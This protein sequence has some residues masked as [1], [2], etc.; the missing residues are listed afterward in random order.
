MNSSLVD[1]DL[2]G[3]K[4]EIDR[5][6]MV[7]MW[8]H[9]ATR[10]PNRNTRAAY[11]AALKGLVEFTARGGGS[12]RDLEPID[13][14]AWLQDQLDRHSIPTAK[15][16]LAGIRS[17]FDGLVEHGLLRS[18]PA[19]AVRAPRYSLRKGKTPVLSPSEARQILSAIGTSSVVGLRDRAIIATML[20]SFARIGAVLRLN[21]EDCYVEQRRL[22]LRLQ[23]KGGKLHQIPCHHELE[24]WLVEYIERSQRPPGGAPLFPSFDR[25]RRVLGD[26]RLA[27]ANAY[28]M[29]RRR[30]GN[31]GIATAICN[32]SFRATGITAYLINGG[33]LENAARLANHAS[34]RTTQ[35]YDRRSDEITLSEVERIRF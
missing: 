3:P 29:V 34:T 1:P 18:N 20:Y 4:N 31:A 17:L 23:E 32:H 13:V 33:T 10:V 16:R 35:L 25:Q 21:T 8:T 19:A 12:L 22:W 2:F 14:A 6:L 11:T 15:Q 9:L 5:Q 7:A 27:H 30:A 28:A 26:R 24:G